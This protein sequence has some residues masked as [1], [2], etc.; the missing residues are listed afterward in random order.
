[1]EER[2]CLSAGEQQS[3]QA[4]P[5]VRRATRRCKYASPRASMCR[6]QTCAL[7]GRTHATVAARRQVRAASSRGS[8]PQ[9]RRQD[10]LIRGAAP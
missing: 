9:Q 8:V 4:L 3:M 1:M 2:A 10:D 7:V 5:L 6:E